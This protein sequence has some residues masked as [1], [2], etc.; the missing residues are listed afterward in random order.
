MVLKAVSNSPKS[1]DARLGIRLHLG[2]RLAIM[3][4]VACE[5]VFGSRMKWHLRD[6]EKKTQ[7][8]VY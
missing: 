4:K 1:Q 5:V 6:I 2:F 3:D 8:K 7:N